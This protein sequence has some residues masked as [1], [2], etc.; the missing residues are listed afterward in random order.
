MVALIITIN[1]TS[2]RDIE[3]EAMNN[4]RNDELLSHSH[5]WYRGAGWLA[6]H[7]PEELK[8]RQEQL[9]DPDLISS[10]EEY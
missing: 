8:R 10:D 3:F 6:R 5:P 4:R 2:M 9:A 1:V 7:D